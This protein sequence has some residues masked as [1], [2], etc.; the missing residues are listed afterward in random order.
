MPQRLLARGCGSKTAFAYACACM[1]VCACISGIVCACTCTYIYTQF[2]AAGQTDSEWEF[3]TPWRIP[4][5]GLSAV[6]RQ[7]THQPSISRCLAPSASLTTHRHAHTHTHTNWPW[8]L[9]ALLCYMV[10]NLWKLKGRRSRV[11][12]ELTSGGKCSGLQ[13]KVVT[14]R[15]CWLLQPVLQH[16]HAYQVTLAKVTTGNL[17][18]R[19]PKLDTN[20]NII[21]LKKTGVH[22]HISWPTV[23]KCLPA[24]SA[25][26]LQMF[27]HIH[28]K[29][30]LNLIWTKIKTKNPLIYSECEWRPFVHWLYENRFFRIVNHNLAC[31]F[32][33]HT[34]CN[35][36]TRLPKIGKA[37]ICLSLLTMEMLITAYSVI[38]NW[39]MWPAGNTG[40]RVCVWDTWT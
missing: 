30:E 38:L 15:F 27:Q 18:S 33:S 24:D 26:L 3:H 31:A 1:C 36:F 14:F 6:C 9:C 28:K 22:T 5:A 29:A 20:I 25:P 11:I 19:V 4:L 39:S 40:L 37:Q 16:D 2:C 8:C 13:E 34:P 12:R 21:F 7:L 23:Y 10:I 32:V 35:R 17:D